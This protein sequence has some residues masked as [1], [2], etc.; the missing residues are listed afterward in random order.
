MPAVA[1]QGPYKLTIYNSD[2]RNGLKIP[3]FQELRIH[4]KS[5]RLFLSEKPAPN[6]RSTFD[7]SVN[8]HNIFYFLFFGGSC[9]DLINV[10]GFII[11]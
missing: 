10:I 8:P 1:I 4:K 3:D 9:T 6:L 7:G 11:M 5:K 2:I